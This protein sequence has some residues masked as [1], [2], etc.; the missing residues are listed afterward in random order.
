MSHPRCLLQAEKHDV[1]SLQ[2]HLTDVLLSSFYLVYILLT[3]D[4][5]SAADIR[6]V[7]RLSFLIVSS[8]YDFEIVCHMNCI[9][10]AVVVYYKSLSF[11]SHPTRNRDIFLLIF[12]PSEFLSTYTTIITRLLPYFRPRFQV[13]SPKIYPLRL[14][15]GGM[16]FRPSSTL[17]P[18][19]SY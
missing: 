13:L 19:M 2:A 18:A 9:D 8:G 12:Q 7:S 10:N 11:L 16:F 3:T 17:T 14:C 4:V 15:P 6:I 5:L 1:A